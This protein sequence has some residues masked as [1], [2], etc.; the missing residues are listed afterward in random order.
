MSSENEELDVD[1]LM[2][3]LGYIFSQPEMDEFCRKLVAGEI[4]EARKMLQEELDDELE[5]EAIINHM[6]E[7]FKI[8]YALAEITP[9]DVV[10]GDGS[11][12]LVNYKG[13]VGMAWLSQYRNE[14][15]LF[16]MDSEAFSPNEASQIWRLVKM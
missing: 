11:S 6:L 2:S 8:K 14:P 12:Y 3:D 13:R 10:Y 7:E 15:L 9:Q 16:R 1:E 4:D 5:V